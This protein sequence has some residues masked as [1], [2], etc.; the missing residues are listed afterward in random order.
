MKKGTRDKDPINPKDIRLLSA[1]NFFLLARQEGVQIMR[2]T[3]GELDAAVTKAEDQERPSILL[4]DL[5]ESAFRD[6]LRGQR[7][8]G[9]WKAALPEQYHDF[10]NYVFANPITLGRINDEDAAKFFAK[11]DKPPLTDDEIRQK[12]PPE[13]HDLLHVARPQEEENLPPHRSYDHKIEL[14]PG[15]PLP[16]SRNKPISP[17][18]LAVVKR[19]LDDNLAKGSLRASTSSTTAP[20]LLARKPGGGIRIY[21][22][23]RGVNNITI[24][25]RYPLPLIRET[26]DAI[27]DAKVYTKLDVIT[28]FNRVRIAAG[29][30]W[31]TAFITR[32]GL[33]E[34][35]VTPFGLYNAPATFQRYINDAL[36]D[37]LNE[38]ATAY[39]DDILI[40]SNNIKD[41]T[42]HV[43]EVLKR[44][45]EAGLQIDLVKYEF[46]VTRTKY[47]G[48]II[49]PR[50]IEIDP[51][52]V[53][54]ITTWESPTTRR[55]LQRF[56]GFANFYRRFIRNFSRLTRC[57]HD[58][59]KKDYT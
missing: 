48:L 8:T 20:L 4:P 15:A 58:L 57:L 45:A 1:P 6:L 3:M 38:Y 36:Y 53:A 26:L 35:L 39:L 16:Y 18:E 30:E 40:Y 23:Y 49:T 32:F 51:E 9:Y 54:A 13:Y 44:L 24:K 42:R 25:N 11:M 22:D 55:Q 21:Q 12:M 34:S 29:H 2:T 41:H 7:D 47:L 33:Y 28:A 59:T 56:L 43:R 10:V 50:G 17:T 52:K 5:T 19:W 31:K 27:C 46:D 37:I 14:L